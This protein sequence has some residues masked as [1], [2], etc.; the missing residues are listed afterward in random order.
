M[1]KFSIKTLLFALAIVGLFTACQEDFADAPAVQ[2]QVAKYTDLTLNDD[3]DLPNPQATEQYADRLF[4]LKDDGDGLTESEVRTIGDPS[5]DEDLAFALLFV[6]AYDRNEILWS[7]DEPKA[8]DDLEDRSGNA[9]WKWTG[10]DPIVSMY[11]SGFKKWPA[12]KV[13]NRFQDP[14][15]EVI[16]AGPVYKK[17]HK[18]CDGNLPSPC[19]TDEIKEDIIGK[20]IADTPIDPYSVASQLVEQAGWPLEANVDIPTSPVT[21]MNYERE[22][23]SGNIVHYKFEVSVGADPHDKIGI[24][25]VV[26]EASP[27][28]PIVTDETVFFQHGDAKDFVGMTLPGLYSP[29]TDNDFG[30]AVFMAQNGVDFWGIDQAWTLVP[31]SAT[32]FGFMADW[33]LEKNFTDLRTGLAI[34][35]IARFLSSDNLE[36][37]HLAGYSSG[38]ATAFA[39][40]NHE[41]QL[42]QVVRHSN[43]CI[44][45]DMLLKTDDAGYNQYW[46]DEYEFFENLI[47]GGGIQ[48][49]IPFSF[50]GG[51]ARNNPD[52][53][54]PIIPGFTN[55]QACLFIGSSPG[56]LGPGNFHY[57]AGEWDNGLPVGL[58]FVTN[59]QWFDF[60]E[61]GVPYEPFIFELDWRAMVSNTIDNP[62]DDYF[63][64]IEV[65][66]LNVSPG[67][68]FGDLTYYGMSLMGSDDVTHLIPKL[69]PDNEAHLDF[70]HIDIFIANNAETV[71]WQPMLDWIQ[72][73]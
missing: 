51:L 4:D 41:T 28:V 43:G 34:A 39:V 19:M 57:L 25:R 31:E 42:E 58:Q 54:S 36:K 53:D 1:K 5:V 30:I 29:N 27:N 11:A 52:D 6:E 44:P 22:V 72:T 9:K 50:I 13:K 16:Q 46:D 55:L 61:S 49:N 3:F 70:G 14:C 40:L 66:I 67:G 38:V 48:D 33:G 15:G 64:E 47:A 32:D 35:R 2:S 20:I 71:M 23:I 68:G 56:L 59:D 60:L 24:H 17:C 63:S 37:L 8:D 45:I 73:H 10:G 26:K 18:L 21:L 7:W 62:F 65:P 12:Y 69:Y